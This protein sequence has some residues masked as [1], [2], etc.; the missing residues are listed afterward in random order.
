M[1]DH[2]LA[3]YVLRLSALMHKQIDDVLQFFQL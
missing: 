2:D 1:T 3:K